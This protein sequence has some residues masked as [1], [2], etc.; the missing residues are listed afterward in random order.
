MQPLDSVL[1]YVFPVF[2]SDSLTPRPAQ[3][4]RGKF[5][6]V[7]RRQYGCVNPTPAQMRLCKLCSFLYNIILPPARSSIPNSI[8][9]GL[10]DTDRQRTEER[11]RTEGRTPLAA[12]ILE[13]N[14]AQN[15]LDWRRRPLKRRLCSCRFPFSFS[16]F[17]L[18]LG[19]S[20]KQLPFGVEWIGK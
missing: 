15:R 4:V 20:A 17:E 13:S 2:C 16:L 9:R 1:P 10:R 14:P 18:T 6:L 19:A 8:S 5:A 12:L 3:S 7:R 11:T